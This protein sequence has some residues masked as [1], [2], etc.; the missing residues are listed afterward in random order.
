[1]LP[2]LT[3]MRALRTR[4]GDLTVSRSSLKFRSGIFSRC[5]VAFLTSDCTHSRLIRKLNL[6]ESYFDSSH[7]KHGLW[8]PVQF[9]LLN[10]RAEVTQRHLRQALDLLSARHLALKARIVTVYNE[11]NNKTEK[12]FEEIGSDVKLPVRCVD[13][14]TDEWESAMERELSDPVDGHLW[15]WVILKGKW[16]RREG[17]RM[18]YKTGIGV[19]SN[20][21]I[22]DA[23]GITNILGE[24]LEILNELFEDPRVENRPGKNFSFPPSLENLVSMPTKSTKQTTDH[25]GG[26]RYLTKFPPPILTSLRMVTNTGVHYIDVPEDLTSRIIQSAKRNHCTLNSVLTS[27]AAIAAAKLIQGGDLKE[28]EIVKA[29]TNYSLRKYVDEDYVPN[30]GCYISSILYKYYIDAEGSE[31]TTFWKLAKQITED[32]SRD[33]MKQRPLGEASSWFEN[34]P[35]P[36]DSNVTASSIEHTINNL[37][38]F[39]MSNMG[40]MTAFE[41]DRQRVVECY[42]LPGAL[43]LS[44]F[45]GS[46]FFHAIYGLN[47]RLSWTISYSN[48]LVLPERVTVYASEILNTLKTTC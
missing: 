2:A 39:D 31:S 35:E 11:E 41:S 10:C 6:L 21:A 33:I 46:V 18:M 22:A 29:Y 16:S 28:R 20:H 19:S 27:A 9:A 13:E 24:L 8:C 7:V 45:M 40:R 32:I 4:S 5:R 3:L 38:T 36:D 14:G 23:I 48:G 37:V 44:P 42:G 25:A 17:D 26:D 30:M 15:R 43:V 12:W 47:G 1:M 34:I